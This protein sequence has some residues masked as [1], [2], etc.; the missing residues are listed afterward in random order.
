MMPA[1]LSKNKLLQV[2]FQTPLARDSPCTREVCLERGQMLLEKQT[3]IQHVYF[4][5]TSVVSRIYLA[6]CGHTSE[7]GMVGREGVVGISLFLGDDRAT[8]EAIVHVSGTALRMEATAALAAYEEHHDFRLALQRYTRAMISQISQ[9]GVCNGLH[10][11]EQ[12]LS[13]WLLMT[14]DRKP[15]DEVGLSHHFIAQMLAVRRESIT[16]AL[17]HLRN[18]HLIRY[19]RSGIYIRDRAGLEAASCECYDVITDEYARLLDFT[20]SQVSIARVSRPL[21][22]KSDA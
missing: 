19:D 11:I 22:P 10:S 15:T 16:S 14:L 4:P 20:P 18:K 8:N 17:L 9:V 5:T 6:N 2:L 3:R 12:R 7:M 13:R 21:T 1:R